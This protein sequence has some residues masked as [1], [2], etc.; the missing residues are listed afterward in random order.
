MNVAQLAALRD[1]YLR[2]RGW[3]YTLHADNLRALCETMPELGNA[4]SYSTVL[5]RMHERD[6][7]PRRLPRNATEGQRKAAERRD[8]LEVRSFESSHVH[9]L[10]HLDFHEGSRRVVDAAGR[11]HTVQLL[12]ILDDRSRL[13]C[14]VQWYL[15]ENTENLVHGLVQAF[16]KRGLPR[17]IMHDN[18]SAM[19]AAET[20]NGITDN[21]IQDQPTLAHSPYQ[22]GKMET[23][24]CQI[25]GRLLPM[26]E[27]VEPLHLDA[28]NLA[29]QAFVER[30]YNITKHDEI[31][32][33]PLAR[34]LE[35]PDV[36]RDAPT[37]A[38]L[39]QTFSVSEYRTQRRSDGTVS[40]AGVRFEMPA[41]LRTLRRP[42]L[43]WQRWDLSVAYVVCERTDQLLARIYP[44]DK[45]SNADG[46][47]RALEPLDEPAAVASRPTRD[48]DPLPPLMRK[49]MQ[50]YAATGLPPAYL[51]KDERRLDEITDSD[52]QDDPKE[53]HHA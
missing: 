9:G 44:L 7:Q 37:T 34:M 31:G 32:T 36:G 8:R 6:W 27:H 41:R 5:R 2:H 42:R 40:I 10:W 49:Y 33:S 28:L 11:Y 20:V 48:D 26:L 25:E 1:Q 52:H 17:A 46:R 24:W 12:G 51:P 18:G 16:H 47:R 35:G 29:T 21:G 30:E 23:F 14:H 53:D 4:P 22:N 15:T 45:E 19:R 39:R 13:C 43:R 50:E 38:A 3:S